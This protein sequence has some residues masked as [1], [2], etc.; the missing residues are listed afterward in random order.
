MSKKSKIISVASFL[1]ILLTVVFFIIAAFEKGLTHD[2]LLEA[3]VLLVSIKVVIASE[4][5][6]ISARNLE[7][8]LDSIRAKLD[9]EN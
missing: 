5:S 3:G 9:E 6:E 4:K 8:K 1:T 2:L 7:M